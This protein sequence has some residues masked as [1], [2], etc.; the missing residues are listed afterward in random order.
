MT[1]S[2]IADLM[3]RAGIDKDCYSMEQSTQF[4]D[5][6]NLYFIFREIGKQYLVPKRKNV[7]RMIPAMRIAFE[8]FSLDHSLSTMHCL[9]CPEDQH[10]VERT[11]NED[12]DEEML[13]IQAGI[14]F[15]GTLN[16]ARPSR[17]HRWKTATMSILGQLCTIMDI[18]ILL[19]SLLPSSSTCYNIKY[20]YSPIPPSL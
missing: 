19:L 15:K 11:H 14:Y 20:L 4:F 18:E 17:R 8:Q 10:L 1:L 16:K 2:E 5:H 13:Y 7:L 3:Q 6:D 12:A 9:L